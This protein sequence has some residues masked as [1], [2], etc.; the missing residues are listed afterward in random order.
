[1]P[2]PLVISPSF[3]LQS[4][5][6][7]ISFTAFSLFVMIYSWLSYCLQFSK[8]T[9]EAKIVNLLMNIANIV[10][11]S[12]MICYIF[13]SY[14]NCTFAHWNLKCSCVKWIR[15]KMSCDGVQGLQIMSSSSSLSLTRT[16][17]A[18]NHN[19]NNFLCVEK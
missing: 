10:N 8:M 5:S 4:P 18:I 19:V 13:H 17:H 1:M 7:L 9:G 11:M 16:G 12:F 15:R 2:F 3:H 6:E 14:E